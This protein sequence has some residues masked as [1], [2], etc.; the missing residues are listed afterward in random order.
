MTVF[1]FFGGDPVFFGVLVSSSIGISHPATVYL[2]GIAM[3]DWLT[4]SV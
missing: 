4:N 3:I 2:V 1:G